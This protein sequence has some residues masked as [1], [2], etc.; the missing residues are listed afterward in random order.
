MPATEL[1]HSEL[2]VIARAMGHYVERDSPPDVLLDI[3]EGNGPDPPMSR[4][5][6]VR[7]RIRRVIRAYKGRVEL[8]CPGD[9]W[10]CPAAQTARCWMS[11]KG[12]V[13]Q[14]ESHQTEE[15]IHTMAEYTR[16]ELEALDVHELFKIGGME[17]E[18]P[19]S[20]VYAMPRDTLITA[21]L[22]KVGAPG[23]AEKEPAEEKPKKKS[24]GKKAPAK[25]K[26][27][28]SEPEPAE[29]EEEGEDEEEEK[30]KGKKAPPKKAAPKK[31]A[32][33]APK[34][35]K[36]AEPEEGEEEERSPAKIYPAA[37]KIDFDKADATDLLHAAI[38]K[39]VQQSGG[40]S[41]G[42]KKVEFLMT[43]HKDIVAKIDEIEGR[44][45]KLEEKL[46]AAEEILEAYDAGWESLL[47]VLAGYMEL[48]D[49][50]GDTPFEQL[51]DLAARYGDD[52][53]E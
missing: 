35:V 50:E 47:V 52:S 10:N 26:L 28:K 1:S 5:D 23:E 15:E 53:G 9:C 3:I 46:E 29:E 34:K 36:K 2:V 37:G 27:K 22:E 12:T 33:P 43:G 21:I 18:I 40:D 24:G 45:D 49:L 4:M 11:S 14:F 30:P 48:D 41:G 16:E 17:A 8:D 51:Q 7:K 38:V 31:G 19:R 42:G 6:S 13:E 39:M 25:K 20:E 44:C 32:K